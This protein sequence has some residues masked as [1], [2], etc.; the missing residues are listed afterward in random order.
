VQGDTGSCGTVQMPRTTRLPVVRGEQHGADVGV[1]SSYARYRIMTRS[2]QSAEP[3][4]H[5]SQE[6]VNGTIADLAAVV[7]PF[8]DRFP[9]VEPNENARAAVLFPGLGEAGV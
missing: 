7:D 2:Q 6:V 4:M 5:G 1:S 9:E 3:S 8:V